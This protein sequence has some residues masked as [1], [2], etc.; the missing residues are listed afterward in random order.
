[1]GIEKR[2]ISTYSAHVNGR[3]EKPNQSIANILATIIH[4]N[5]DWD[6]QLTHTM[7]TLNSAIHEAAYTSPF[8]LEHGRDICL[9]YSYQKE[10]DIPRDSYE[11]ERNYYPL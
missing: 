11:F 4:D 9:S 2:H 8:F 10:S 5:N 6:E 1:M 3:V 7:L